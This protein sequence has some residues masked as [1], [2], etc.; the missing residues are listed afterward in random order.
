MDNSL[1]D[2]FS[3]QFASVLTFRLMSLAVDKM[4]SWSLRTLLYVASAAAAERRLD[5]EAANGGC[6][7]SVTS[8]HRRPPPP[9]YH[10]LDPVCNEDDGSVSVARLSS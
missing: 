5:G 8:H 1:T 3:L 10:P 9:P 6:Y 7:G 4:L 2:T